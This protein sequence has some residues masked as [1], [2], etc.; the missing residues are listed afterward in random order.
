MQTILFVHPS[1]HTLLPLFLQQVERISYPSKLAAM[2][3]ITRFTAVFHSFINAG[4]QNASGD[5]TFKIERCHHGPLEVSIRDGSTNSNTPTK[6]FTQK[7]PPLTQG[8]KE[9]PSPLRIKQVKNKKI[10]EQNEQQ[11]KPS[12]GDTTY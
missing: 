7:F 1:T 10:I 3:P 6:S 4:T 12:V 11:H 2:S 5:V 9:K 8:Q